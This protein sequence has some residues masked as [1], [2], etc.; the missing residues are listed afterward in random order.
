VAKSFNF[1]RY[2]RRGPKREERERGVPEQKF[3]VP[4][5]TERKKRHR[6]RRG[7]ETEKKG[8]QGWIDDCHIKHLLFGQ[9]EG[10]RKRSQK[11]R[12]RKEEKR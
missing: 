12:R 10:K 8:N 5:F 11:E 3:V 2:S 6:K 7:G 4:S 9:R 1:F